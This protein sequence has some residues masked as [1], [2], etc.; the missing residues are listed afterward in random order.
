MPAVAAAALLVDARHR[1]WITSSRGLYRW[2][3]GRRNCDGLACRTAPAANTSIAVPCCGWRAV[4]SDR[5]RRLVMVDTTAADRRGHGRRCASMASRSVAMASGEIADG[6]VAPP[7]PRGPGTADPCPPAG[8]RRS[9]GEPLLVAAGGLRTRLGHLGRQWRTR[10][11][12]PGARSLHVADARAGC[13]RERS[14]GTTLVFVVPPPW[15][16]TA[17]AQAG[18]VALLLLALFALA[19]AYRQRLAWTC[20]AAGGTRRRHWPSRRRRRSRVSWRP[21]A[22]KYG[23]Q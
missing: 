19:W 9:A 14:G 8:V 5:R 6:H 13:R 20:V 21:W 2:E 1:V 4:G 17:W 22:T 12:R 16:R 18:F 3:P 10:L 7:R 15:W 23:R 11:H